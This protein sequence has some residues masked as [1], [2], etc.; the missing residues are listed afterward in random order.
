MMERMNIQALNTIEETTATQFT[1][2]SEFVQ[3]EEQPVFAAQ[4]SLPSQR[5]KVR[6]GL[7][8]GFFDYFSLSSIISTIRVLPKNEA[9][10]LVGTGAAYLAFD[11][12]FGLSTMWPMQFFFALMGLVCILPVLIKRREW[13]VMPLF[14]IFMCAIM[15]TQYID[16]T[17]E[18]PFMRFYESVS[19]GMSQSEVEERLHQAFPTNGKYSVPV[20]NPAPNGFGITLDPSRGEY[21]ATIIH[22]GFRDDR[23][24]SK[25]Y[26]HD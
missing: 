16:W 24:V 21:N 8:G 13:A 15:G 7:G 3:A 11:A 6:R 20:M 2:N 9:S 14:A 17:P 5:R 10:K 12:L 26:Y 1:G 22:L 4:D 23:V 25:D 19:A 18:K